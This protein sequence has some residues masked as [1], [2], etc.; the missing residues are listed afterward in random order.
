MITPSVEIA[1]S[2][3]PLCSL[4]SLEDIVISCEL[5]SRPVRAKSWRVELDAMHE[6]ARLLPAGSAVVLKRLA[7]MAVD[8]CGAH[9]GG[10]SILQD[11]DGGKQ[12]FRWQALAGDFAPYE[13]GATPREWSPCGECLNTGKAMLYSYP[14]RFFTY[15]SASGIPIVE[16]LVIP[17]LTDGRPVGTIWIVSSD[18]VRKF[19]AG[20][21]RVMTSLGAFVAAAIQLARRPGPACEDMATE[22]E[23]VW[24]EWMRRLALGD[25]SA[26]EPLM[27][28]TRP[29]VF[30]RALRVLGSPADADEATAD[31]YVQILRI[32]DRYLVSR[33]TV[34]SWLL[35][36]TRSRAVDRLRARLRYGHLIEAV[37]FFNRP[38]HE[39]P[40]SHAKQEQ[41]RVQIGRAMLGLPVQQRQLIEWAYF[42]GYSLPEIAARSRE[43]LGTI[44]SRMRA[45]LIKLRLQLSSQEP[46]GAA[47][48]VAR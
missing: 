21:V 2:A 33:Q 47:A 20:D 14:A 48:L 16:G 13:G 27:E 29:F 44:K 4:A 39:D 10:I 11:T 17:L 35:T 1:S 19:D 26:L 3:D 28:E 41:L 9:S 36:L 18:E 31:V 34:L 22:R 8:L 43:P 6:L 23:A 40:E 12:V 24:R 5:L 30:A 32:A 42:E 25:T 7:Q 37:V 46:A 15:L 45:S 38:A